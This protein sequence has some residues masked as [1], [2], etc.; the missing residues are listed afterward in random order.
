MAHVE[1]G[2]AIPKAGKP[3]RKSVVRSTAEQ[4]AYEDEK[5]ARDVER[6]R[7]KRAEEK[8]KKAA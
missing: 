2:P 3:G 8:L 4:K 6:K 7:G 1:D 5:R